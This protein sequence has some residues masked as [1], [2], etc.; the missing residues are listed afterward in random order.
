MI[1]GV[2]VPGTESIHFHPCVAVG[3]HQPAAAETSALVEGE[4]FPVHE[5]PFFMQVSHIHSAFVEV[6]GRIGRVSGFQCAC[7]GVSV[8]VCVCVAEGSAG[9]CCASK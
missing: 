4:G 5:I 3:N 8:C 1:G 7:M 6:R 2:P 9:H